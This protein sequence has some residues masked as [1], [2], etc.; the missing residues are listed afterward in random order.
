MEIVIRI[1]I[2]Y[3][4][5]LAGL[6][7]LGKREFG[8]LSPHE[9]VTLLIIPEIVS[10][11][12]TDQDNSITGALIGTATLMGLVFITSLLTHRF[13][14]LEEIVRGQPLVLVQDGRLLEIP[15]NRSRVSADEVLAE[16]RKSGYDQLEQ[17]KWAVLEA[18]GKISFVPFESA[19]GSGAESEEMKTGPANA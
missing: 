10:Q 6:R 19:P 9:L 18:D 3:L 1:A 13:E 17:I 5:I 2:I 8:Q 12:L 16:M 15:L 11:A 14:R 7:V 4:F